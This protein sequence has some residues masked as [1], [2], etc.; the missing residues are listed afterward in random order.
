VEVGCVEGC[1]AS[2]ELDAG[3]MHPL[4]IAGR[5]DHFGSFRACPARS[6]E[7]DARAAADHEERLADEEQSA[8]HNNRA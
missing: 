7:P 4:G 5:N 1:D 3:P 2:A 6:L 8:T